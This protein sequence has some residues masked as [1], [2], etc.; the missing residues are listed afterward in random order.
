MFKKKKWFIPLDKKP[1]IYHKL[2]YLIII[3]F[4]YNLVWFRFVIYISYFFRHFN[5]CDFW[6]RFNLCDGILYVFFMI[7]DGFLG[8]AKIIGPIIIYPYI[9]PDIILRRFQTVFLNAWIP[10][11][12]AK[13]NLIKTF[14]IRLSYTKG[15]GYKNYIYVNI[16]QLSL[17]YFDDGA[18]F[19]F[20]LYL[21][22][23]VY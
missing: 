2:Y 16:K 5:N 19:F 17:F 14:T 13:V 22:I 15:A 4:G 21:F 7:S 8:N 20:I 18:H 12:L 1:S 11:L 6:V 3:Y 10:A 9:K 23:K